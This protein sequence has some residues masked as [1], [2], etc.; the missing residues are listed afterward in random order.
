MWDKP[1]PI[2]DNY[3]GGLLRTHLDCWRE[4]VGFAWEAGSE[5]EYAHD[6]GVRYWLQIA[7]EYS[8]PSTQARLQAL[9]DPLD[10]EFKRRMIPA[11]LATYASSNP[12]MGRPY[13]WE[14]HTLIGAAP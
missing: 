5:D 12:F 3:G 9:L 6:I 11:P 8:T 4:F 13:F 7:L 2:V 1:S 14:T 10:A